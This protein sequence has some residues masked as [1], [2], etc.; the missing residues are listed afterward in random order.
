MSCFQGYHLIIGGSRISVWI[1]MKSTGAK[2]S[3]TCTQKRKNTHTS[4]LNILEFKQRMRARFRTLDFQ[5]SRQDLFR[6][7]PPCEAP[8]TNWAVGVSSVWVA[9]VSSVWVAGVS[10][11][12]VAGVAS[13]ASM[14]RRQTSRAAAPICG[15]KI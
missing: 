13:V 11:I 8:S 6:R 1:Q 12:W 3:W 5:Y 15:N 14:A 9:G 2:E 10:S 7:K 4:C